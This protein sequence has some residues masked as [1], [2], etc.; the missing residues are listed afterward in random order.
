MQIQ[1]ILKSFLDKLARRIARYN[2]GF[3]RTREQIIDDN[4]RLSKK[5]LVIKE[6]SGSLK[7]DN[8]RLKKELSSVK[9]KY[10]KLMVIQPE[11]DKDKLY[12]WAQRV[13]EIGKCDICESTENLSAH[14]LWDKKTH[15]SLVYQDENGV[16]LCVTCHNAFHKRYTV[17]SHV[18]PSMYNKFKIQEE[19]AA[20]M[21]LRFK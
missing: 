11:L 8:T 17:K 13:K 21:A 7:A 9:S 2:K 6:I 3:Y 20:I 14:H 1:K 12:A 19:T 5:N 10:D 15:P 4:V 18:T 16:C